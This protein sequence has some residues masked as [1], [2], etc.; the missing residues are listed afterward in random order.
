MSSESNLKDAPVNGP[1]QRTLQLPVH[2]IKGS[3]F[4]VVH[5]SGAWF[6]GDPQ[7]NLHLTFFNDR[8]PIPQ[9]TVLNLDERG[10]V[11][12]EDLSQRES[13]QG[14]IRE[15]E[16]DVVFSIQSAVDFYRALGDNLKAL[17]AI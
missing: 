5:A 4:R 14:V 9:I 12:G 15:M 13:K 11:L 7:Q 17:K 16:V 8:T 6:G 10:M 1:P 3:S 2:F